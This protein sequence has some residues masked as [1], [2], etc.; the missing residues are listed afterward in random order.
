VSRAETIVELFPTHGVVRG[1][2]DPLIFKLATQ[3]PDRK[4]WSR[5]QLKFELSE[6]NLT[7][8]RDKLEN[9]TWKTHA[10]APAKRVVPDKKLPPDLMKFSRPPREGQAEAFE[11]LRHLDGAAI[12]MDMGTGKSYVAIHLAAWWWASG[13]I[14][15]VLLIAPSE[16][17]RQWYTEQLPNN[18][19]AWLSWHG[20]AAKKK[21]L[22]ERW[23]TGPLVDRPNDLAW[24][25]LNFEKVQRAEG[26]QR[27]K[28]FVEGGQALILVDEST[29]IKTP[30][31]KQTQYITRLRD[32]SHKRLILSGRPTTKGLEDLFSQ[33]RFLDKD[34]LGITEYTVFKRRYCQMGGWEGKQI[35]GY[36]DV[37]DLLEK[38]E[39]Y[40]FTM[41][42]TSDYPSTY[43]T[44][45][46]TLNPEQKRIYK[47]LKADLFAWVGE[48]KVALIQ[49]DREN[50]N[51]YC[52]NAAVALVRMQQV[53]CGYIQDKDEDGDRRVTILS[54]VRPELTADIVEEAGDQ[55]VIIYCAYH[56]CI[57]LVC[58]ALN[59]RNINYIEVSG[60]TRKSRSEDVDLFKAGKVPV[61]VGT[62]ASGGIGLDL[63]VASVTIYFSNTNS[64]EDREQS[65][66]RTD[67][68]GQTRGVTYV[69]IIGSPVDKKI[70]ESN[71]VKK[72][73]GDLV[74]SLNPKD[75]DL[76]T[77]D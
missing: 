36:Q 21:R 32:A 44:R 43:R 69:D 10:K 59:K 52:A 20:I 58:E 24:W 75:L 28:K 12:F 40:T 29:G 48:A 73:I 47:E 66:A 2:L 5:G 23:M 11:K 51:V 60:R 16:V 57:D 55:K 19:P 7:L 8:L 15:R 1:R 18:A 34:I 9:A 50:Y 38:I 42:K 77:L 27:C 39:P 17:E 49:E 56:P 13:L 33:F 6:G 41:Q 65:K 46:H 26:Y 62:A 3:L 71:D 53:T 70:I 45:L 61:M 25:F 4:E 67:R 64:S 30:K 14:N 76:E 35:V 74:M 22:V 72:T 68:I 37:E 63:S 54:T 31:S